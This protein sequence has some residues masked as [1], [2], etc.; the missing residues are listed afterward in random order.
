MKKHAYRILSLLLL[1][2]SIALSGC[3]GDKN[4]DKQN[5]ETP[6]SNNMS[7]EPTYGGDVVVGIQ[8]DLDSL[9]PH[10]AVAAGTSE[11]LFNIFEGLVKPTENGDL[12]PAVASDYTISDDGTVY[13]FVLRDGIKFH[14]GSLVTVE[15]IVYS[16]KRSAG[17]LNDGDASINVKS[18]LKNITEV[19]ALDDKTVQIVLST[20]DTELLAYL[21]TAIIPA[22][23]DK[24]E[25]NP[26]GTGPFKYV[27]F[28][29]QQ[30]LVMEKNDDYWGE[31]PYLDK[32]TFKIVEKADTAMM[33]LQ[34][35]TIDIFPYLTVDQAN[36]LQS[37]FNIEIGNM[38][39]VQGLFL[40]NGK[41]PFNDQRVR[42][43]LN[44]A[45]NR[46]EI[47]DFVAGGNG[48]IIQSGVFSGFTKYY[49]ETLATTYTQDLEKAKAL[50]AEAGYGDNNKL[51][52]TITVPSGYQ[53]HIDT[54][55]VIVEQLSKIG[56][57]AKIQLIE[58]TAWLSDVYT[59]RN[60]EAT[61]I[62]LDA[63]LAASDLL[64]RYGS[65]APNNFVNY[66]NSEYDTIL[67]EALATTDDEKKVTDYK[68]LQKI[69]TEDS[70][71]VYIAD[72]S[73]M[74]AVNKKLSGY[75]FY[76][77]YVQDMSKVYFVK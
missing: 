40:N 44:Y 18:A 16:I 33:E 24:L 5:G 15:D 28:A 46:Q 22:N 23:Y 30:S 35:G 21:T 57:T 47:L 69:L 50:L 34:G 53:Y 61:I 54:A 45:V 67:A 65:T 31:K 7:Q 26:I 74:V 19:T 8:Q 11:V 14:N 62:G 17:L 55:Q 49:D 32:V 71:A 2:C 70:A 76:P 27:S 59:D 38:N 51:T 68:K 37:Q 20:P 41:A 25:S 29:H 3:S 58:W 73:L 10:K 77:V 36:Q 75:T 42:E 63:P 48:T 66:S 9:D 13:T 56:V 1:V 52:F 60:Y 6:D 43:A 39:L 4:N 72:P 12:V 64:G